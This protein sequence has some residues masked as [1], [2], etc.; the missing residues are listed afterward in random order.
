MHFWAFL[1]STCWFCV[2]LNCLITKHFEFD[3]RTTINRD[4]LILTPLNQKGPPFWYKKEKNCPKAF[5]DSWKKRPDAMS[6]TQKT[7]ALYKVWFL[8]KSKKNLKK[9][10]NQTKTDQKCIFLKRFFL[11]FSETVHCEELGGFVLHSVHWDASFEPS[12]K[13]FGQFF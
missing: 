5:F 13:A 4:K 11:I 2:V 10:T 9:K 12:E 6:V 1:C 8:K 3:W 7:P